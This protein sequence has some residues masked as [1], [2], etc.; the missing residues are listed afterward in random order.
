MSQILS[1]KTVAPDFTLPVS[2]DKKLTLSGTARAAG[3]SGLLSSR[4]W[5]PVC[6]DQMALYNEIL[7]EFKNHNA[8]L[9]GISVDGVWCHAAICK[10]RS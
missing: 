7:P 4:I 6:G 5:S 10:K 3:D 2:P 8:A 1:P 9:F